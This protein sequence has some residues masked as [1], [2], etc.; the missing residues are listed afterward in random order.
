MNDLGA[1]LSKLIEKFDIK[2]L[3]VSAFIMLSLMLIPKINF[4]KDLMPLNTSEK[5]IKAIFG[6]I[7]IYILLC[8][9]EF[10]FKRIKRSFNNRPKKFFRTIASYGEYLSVF[11]SKDIGYEYTS[12]PINLKDCGIPDDVIYKLLDSNIIEQGIYNHSLYKLNDIALK[13]MNRY[14][15]IVK[16]IMAKKENKNNG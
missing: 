4:L 1:F 12:K 16:F 11:L 15:K 5:L 7:A 13:R 3:L 9:L 6:L 14:N 10:V 8:V 2:K